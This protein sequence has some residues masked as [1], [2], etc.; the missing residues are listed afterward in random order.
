M[1]TATH[2]AL[3]AVILLGVTFALA[4]LTLL[5]PGRMRLAFSLLVALVALG[6]MGSFEFV[7]ESIR[8]PYRDRQLLVRKLAVCGQDS[9]RRRIQRGRS[10]RRRHSEIREMDQPS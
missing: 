1:P 4:L 6:A 8:K 3:F 2:F 9:G 7:R 10:Q 5:R